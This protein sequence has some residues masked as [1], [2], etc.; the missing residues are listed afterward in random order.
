VPTGY[1]PGFPERI[2]ISPG[3]LEKPLVKNRAD[4]D[5]FL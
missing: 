1:P 5:E 3:I 2:A 4:E